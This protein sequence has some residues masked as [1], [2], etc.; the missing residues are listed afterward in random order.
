MRLGDLRIV[1]GGGPLFPPILATRGPGGRSAKHAHHAMHLVLAIDGVLR[2]DGARAPGVLTMPDV[3]HAIDAVGVEVLLVFLDPESDAGRLLVSE[4][5]RLVDA[6]ERDRILALGADPL[7]IMTSGRWLDDAARVLGAA[8]APRRRID[9]RVRRALA[10]A[11]EGMATSLEDLAG[12]VGLSPSRFMHVFTTS[13]GIPLRPYLAWLK[14]QRA[15]AAI[16]SG[17]PLASAAA[18]AGF[19]DAAHMTRSF[20]R[21]FGVTPSE[22]APSR[23]RPSTR[24]RTSPSRR[25]AGT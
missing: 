7:A 10:I 2:V 16:V 11:R 19:S 20:R 15:A 18:S 13:V 9:P 22:L 3:P 1:A 25:S 12:S 17:A 8:R 14:L 4:D 23:R 24:A 5:V 21:M 6:G